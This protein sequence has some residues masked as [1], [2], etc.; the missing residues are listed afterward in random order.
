MGVLFSGVGVLAIGAPHKSFDTFWADDVALPA[1]GAA[2]YDGVSDNNRG[3]GA[4][5]LL[6]YSAGAWGTLSFVL[7]QACAKES[8]FG[9]CSKSQTH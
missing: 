2:C 5:M 8:F 6:P 9:Q 4:V 3:V 7:P 1:L